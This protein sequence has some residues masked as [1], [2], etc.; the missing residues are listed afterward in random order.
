MLDEETDLYSNIGSSDVKCCQEA[1]NPVR[2]RTNLISESVS[3]VTSDVLYIF[4]DTETMGIN[5]EKDEIFRIAASSNKSLKPCFNQY[6]LPSSPIGKDVMQ[7]NGLSMHKGRLQ[8][9]RKAVC[10]DHCGA[11]LENFWH[12][13]MN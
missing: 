5:Q 2:D 13:W 6:I 9:N 7:L 11:I 8:W 4:V 10:A 1:S 3:N 12:T